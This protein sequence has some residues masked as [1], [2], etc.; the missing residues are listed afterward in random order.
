MNKVEIKS[1]TGV[2]GIAALFV[3][4]HHWHYFL[5]TSN[6]LN[7]LSK[8]YLTVLFTHGNWSVDLFFILSGFLLSITSYNEFKD[9]IKKTNYYN[10][11]IKRFCR[12]Y[13][14]YIA[15]TLCYFLAE[16]LFTQHKTSILTII[17]NL[18]LFQ[19]LF[20]IKNINPLAW[21]LSVE[22]A[23]Y[24]LLPVMFILFSKISKAYIRAF[25]LY[26][27]SIGIILFITKSLNHHFYQNHRFLLNNVFLINQNYVSIITT[28]YYPVL[29]GLASY[30]LGIATFSLLDSG[31]LKLVPNSFFYLLFIVQLALLFSASLLANVTFILLIPFMLI[32][33]TRGNSLL[34]KIF[35]T[36]PIYFLGEISFS[37]YLLHFVFVMSISPRLERILIQQHVPHYKYILF[38]SLLSVVIVLSSFLYYYLE[39]PLNARLRKQ[40]LLKQPSDKLVLHPSL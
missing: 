27:L 3:V 19:S 12:V 8:Y 29:R 34:S 33:L 5:L 6:V 35:S 7:P 17:A 32:G 26:L 9:G 1:L 38:F 36:K 37:L 24:F 28:G 11:I 40:L 4:F 13:P 2:R 39:K 10:F 16:I 23:I 14:I 21:S 18:T 25:T 31:R 20:D 30:L 22:W 15:L